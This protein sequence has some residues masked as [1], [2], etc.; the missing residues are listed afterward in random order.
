MEHRGIARRWHC[1][2]DKTSPI[3]LGTG[4]WLG[5]GVE[6]S[7]WELLQPSN[8]HLFTIDGIAKANQ[9]RNRMVGLL[10]QFCHFF[11]SSNFKT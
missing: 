6:L 4:G 3:V 8:E 7:G 5:L 9:Y 11:L 2:E 10:P 1:L